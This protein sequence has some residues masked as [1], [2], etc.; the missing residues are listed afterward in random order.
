MRSRSMAVALGIS[1]VCAAGAVACYMR[2]SSLHQEAEWMNARGAAEAQEYAAT[3]DG[4]FAD[5]Q[6]AM[7]DQ[8][9]TAVDRIQRW[10]LLERLLIL[11]TVVAGFS[12]YVFYLF[13]R[14]RDQLVDATSEADL[15][16]AP[17]DLHV[18]R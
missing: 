6:L 9:R 17:T 5:Q 11:V 18:L 14:L 1:I 16:G 7:F 2:A 8:H 15:T 4:H 3:F 13:R 10:Q 12:G